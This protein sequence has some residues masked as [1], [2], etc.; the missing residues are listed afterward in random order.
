MIFIGTCA[1]G[2]DVAGTIVLDGGVLDGVVS[3]GVD[4]STSYILMDDWGG[5]RLGLVVWDDTCLAF[6]P[7]RLGRFPMSKFLDKGFLLYPTDGRTLGWV[8]RQLSSPTTYFSLFSF[9][10][11]IPKVRNSKTISDVLQ[12]D[13]Q[14]WQDA[15]MTIK[16]K[17]TSS[18]C[19][20]VSNGLVWR[21][22]A[23]S[24]LGKTS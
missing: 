3:V 19:N 15:Q 17:L 10:V 7:H 11:D 8:S 4:E 21:F 2:W 6:L 20:L 14:V 18:H 9:I 13:Q 23:K 12:V 22:R 1:E 24:P 16:W 5:G